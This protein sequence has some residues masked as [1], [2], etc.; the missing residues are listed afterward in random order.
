MMRLRRALLGRTG[1]A[2]A[3][4]SA[5]AG[6]ARA[7]PGSL[8]AEPGPFDEPPAEPVILDLDEL[9]WELRE[10]DDEEARA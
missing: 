1:R 7:R 5:F 2:G 4:G 8:V 9:P 6:A 10:A 3:I